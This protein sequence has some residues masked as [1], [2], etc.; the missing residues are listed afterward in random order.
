MRSLRRFLIRLF[1]LADRR[2]HE[3]RLKEEMAEHI[4][5]E[6][7]ENLRAGLPLPMFA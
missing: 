6:T 1:N 4:A 7:E 3:Q 2:E 5:L